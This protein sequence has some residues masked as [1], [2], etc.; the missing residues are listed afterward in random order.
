[1]EVKLPLYNL[2]NMLLTGFVFMGSCGLIFPEEVFQFLEDGIIQKL[3]NGPEIIFVACVFAAAYEFGMIINRVGSVIIEWTMKRCSFIPFDDDYAK[4][5]ECRKNYPI[6]EVLSRE[7][8]LSRTSATLFLG[9]S[10]VSL[11]SCQCLQ[12]IAF[13]LISIIYFVSCR[14]YAK[15]IVA[16]M[17]SGGD[18]ETGN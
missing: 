1:M 10:I 18:H 2:L 7:Y 12:C 6:M 3:S 9:L 17:H 5:N 4:F 14:K 16:L 11:A 8:A 13:L 15:K